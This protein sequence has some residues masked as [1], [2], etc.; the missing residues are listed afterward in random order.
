MCSPRDEI[1][2][3]KN[4]TA[5]LPQLVGGNGVT[6]VFPQPLSQEEQAALRHSV[7]I[8]KEAIDSLHLS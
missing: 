2:G 4:V 8:L 7:E 5:S 3:V 1:A 6:T